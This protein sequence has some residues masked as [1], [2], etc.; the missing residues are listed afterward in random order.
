M[1]SQEPSKA[2]ASTNR[3]GLLL[4]DYKGAES[5]LCA[6]CGHDA[7]T[8]QIIRAFFQYG[9]EPHRVIK[10]SG[11]GCSSKTPAYFLG[12]AHGFNA[13]HGRMP[14][15]GTGALLANHN[16]IAIGVSGDGDTASI[17]TGQFV[18][19]LRRNIPMIY[20]MENNGVYG[21]TKGQFS[22]TADA[23][24]KLKTGVVN[25]LPPID[26]CALAIELGCGYVAR[27]F[28]GDPKQLVALLEGALAHRGTAFL[29]VI[30]P[31]VTFN[32]HEG[33]TKSYKYA[34]EAEELL[35]EVS[36]IPFFEQ[37]SVDYEEGATKS[38]ELHDG[39]HITLRKLWRDFDPG[40]FVE[41]LR[42][43]HE[44]RQKE[45][46]VTGLLYV[47]PK[48]PDFTEFLDLPD[49]PLAQLPAEITRPS[50]AALAEIMDS[51]R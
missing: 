16:L 33:S 39:S 32:N 36:F 18:H 47:D 9:V 26:C 25:D 49:E 37:I 45:E 38:V 44:S 1:P 31:C 34:K 11:I 10:L 29:D 14:A 43:L 50:R 28:A 15:V 24:S 46:F 4:Q 6:G 42:V 3:V 30:S 13:V 40:N 20:I 8:S 41:A 19:L 12:R 51:L 22:A 21:L 2:K 5:T 35:H 17:G 48:K 27:S 7:I 23:G